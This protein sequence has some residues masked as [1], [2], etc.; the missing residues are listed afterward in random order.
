VLDRGIAAHGV[1]F[2]IA[3]ALRML[4]MRAKRDPENWKPVF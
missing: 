3:A 4:I 2:T 1:E